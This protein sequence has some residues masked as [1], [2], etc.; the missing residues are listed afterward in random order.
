MAHIFGYAGTY[1]SPDAPGTYRFSLDT[2]TGLLS[3]P[4]LLYRQPNTK[5]S[6][7][8]HGLLATL[9]EEGDRAGLA[10]I[11]AAAPGAP[12]LGSVLTEKVTGC[13]LTWHEGLVYTTN[14]HDGH[15]LVY[16]PAEGSLVLR[17]RIFVGEEAGCHQAIFHGRWLLVP[18]LCLDQIRIFDLENDCAPAGELDFPAG[19]G[20]RHGVF[21]REHTR[22]F[23]VSETTNQLF[24]YRV[25]G[26]SFTLEDAQ[27]LLPP[28]EQGKPQ[29]AAI[30]LA[31][32][33]RTLYI[34][35]RGADLIVVLSVEGGTPKLLQRADAQGRDPWDLLLV[36]GGGYALV[37]NRKSDEILSFALA[38]DG[39][40]AK[41]RSSIPVPQ[42]VGL[43][44]E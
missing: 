41:K 21:N 35:I 36:P 26:L 9:T 15:V 23:L 34:S 19:T 22:F 30:R 11:D 8:D 14:Y 43:S 16:A 44:L 12:L 38:A 40:L 33:Q 24:T 18:C 6:G 32:D 10:L 4:Q 7:Y 27:D 5:Y 39:T 25:D 2:K 29:A 1:A 13:F 3:D 28:G 31:E 17:R 42:C 37:S 20:P